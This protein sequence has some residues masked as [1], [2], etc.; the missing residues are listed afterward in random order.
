[1]MLNAVHELSAA[2]GTWVNVLFAVIN[3]AAATAEAGFERRMV[4]LTIRAHQVLQ[5]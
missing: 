1:M 3:K 2:I 4:A 5:S